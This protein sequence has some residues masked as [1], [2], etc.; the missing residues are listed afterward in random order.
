[1]A[2]VNLP[3]VVMNRGDQSELVAADVKDSEF[4]DLID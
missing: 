2:D 4:S 3:P 1:M